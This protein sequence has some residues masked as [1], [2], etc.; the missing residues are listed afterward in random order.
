MLHITLAK[1]L[2]AFEKIKSKRRQRESD[3]K[4]KEFC[5]CI[6]KVKSKRGLT[7]EILVQDKGNNTL[8]LLLWA[9]EKN[10]MKASDWDI[11]QCA[12]ALRSWIHFR[13]SVPSSKNWIEAESIAEREGEKEYTMAIHFHWLLCV[14]VSSP[15]R[16]SFTLNKPSSL[17]P[18]DAQGG[19]INWLSESSANCSQSV[20]SQSLNERVRKKEM[21]LEF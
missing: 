17:I 18:E 15:T 19:Y 4:R 2:K 20:T 3:K 14:F 8:K 13:L 7:F 6:G 11:C 12:N 16:L 10:G 21:S 1:R 9:K 5:R